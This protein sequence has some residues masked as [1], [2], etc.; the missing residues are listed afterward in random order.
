MAT[1]TESVKESLLGTTREPQ[2]SQ[3]TKAEFDKHAI[4]DEETGELYMTEEQFIEAVAPAN[5]DYVS[6]KLHLL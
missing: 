6:L 5:E 2:L 4:R 1:V 3:Q